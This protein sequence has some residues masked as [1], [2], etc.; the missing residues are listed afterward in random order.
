MAG[1]GCFPLTVFVTAIGQQF[2]L[3]HFSAKKHNNPLMLPLL[4]S[5]LKT[6]QLGRT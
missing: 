6:Q 4:P 1:P 3:K 2:K 5:F